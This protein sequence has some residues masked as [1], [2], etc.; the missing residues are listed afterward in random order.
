MS[1]KKV[2]WFLGIALTVFGNGE[3]RLFM[4]ELF[5]LR[6][7]YARIYS[8]WCRNMG[9]LWGRLILVYRL[10]GMQNGPC[11]IKD[12]S[13]NC[14][15]AVG[16]SCA[17]IAVVVRT[18]EGRWYFLFQKGWTPTSLFRQRQKLSFGLFILLLLLIHFILSLKGI[19]NYVLMLLLVEA[20]THLGQSLIL[21]ALLESCLSS[22][23]FS[24]IHHE[25]NGAAH[26][27]ASW[28]CKNV[29][30]TC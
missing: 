13:K 23:C 28:S 2:S 25:A 10:E 4:K 21:L 3:I 6:R 19:P 27:L 12:H 22:F 16:R 26:E 11:L 7:P 30:Y 20:V 9:V 5:H 14:D 15:A 8:Y 24:W 29:I 1:K 17:F 18:G